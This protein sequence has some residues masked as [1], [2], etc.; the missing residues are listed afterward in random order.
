MKKKEYITPEATPIKVVTMILA[1][2]TTLEFSE[3]G[4]YAD[5]DEEVL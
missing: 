5:P 4:E 1:G 3:E 2:S